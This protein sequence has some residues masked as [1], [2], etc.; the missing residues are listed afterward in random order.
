MQNANTKNGSA[1]FII[2]T[3]LKLLVICALV[4]ALVAFVNF[5][6]KDRI[7]LNEKL[8]TASALTDIYS[9]DDLEFYVDDNGNY[10]IRKTDGSDF[11]SCGLTD[12]EEPLKDVDAV[13]TIKDSSGN[14]FGYCVETSPMGFKDE[15][16]M[17][18]AVTPSVSVKD[19]QIISISDTKGIGDK[20]LRRDFLD[21]F[22]DKT[23]GFTQ[24][25]AA[26]KDIV[27]AG[28]TRTSEPVTKAVDTALEQIRL[29]TGSKNTTSEEG[30]GNE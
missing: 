27:I 5:V 29:L 11:G 18:V 2:V 12:I 23:Y 16:G 7:E 19:V 14:V 24:S 21:K 28:S 22:T 8:S 1:K 25:E 20:V 10:A 17:I 26:L 15:V 6:T 13:Y 30:I 4:A 9:S 3:A